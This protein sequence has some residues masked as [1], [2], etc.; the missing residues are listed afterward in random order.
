MDVGVSRECGDLHDFGGG[1]N[2]FGVGS[3]EFDDNSFG[4]SLKIHGLQ[5]EVI[6][7]TPSEWKAPVRRVVVVAHHPPLCSSLRNVLNKENSENDIF[8]KPMT[9][10]TEHPGSRADLLM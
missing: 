8:A 3:E 1:G 5:P 6:F 7:V 2:V 10:Y 9:R 4:T